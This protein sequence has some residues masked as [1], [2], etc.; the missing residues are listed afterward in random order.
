VFFFF[1]LQMLSIIFLL[2]FPCRVFFNF[3]NMC[4]LKFCELSMT[5]SLPHLFSLFWILC[6][7][8][9]L[10]IYFVLLFPVGC[11]FYLLS[12]SNSD[13]LPLICI[14]F[15]LS[16]L[17]YCFLR[18]VMDLITLGV[19]WF[20]FYFVY[21]VWQVCLFLASVL[22]IVSRRSWSLSFCAFFLRLFWL[23]FSF[24]LITFS[25][26]LFGVL[27]SFTFSLIL[28]LYFIIT[29]TPLPTAAEGNP[30]AGNYLIIPA[31]R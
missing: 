31:S 3:R 22:V 24:F 13:I 19:I 8:I 12:V 10:V 15:F 4:H 14:G 30:I 7:F 6:D 26:V 27:A 20:G 21:S 25:G 11:M 2:N 23:I 17:W 28:F 29:R 1:F 9:P 5:G 16:G 18:F